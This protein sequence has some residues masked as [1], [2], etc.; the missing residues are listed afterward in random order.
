MAIDQNTSTF[1]RTRNVSNDT[2]T[3]MYVYPLDSPGIIL[4]PT[5]FDGEG[6]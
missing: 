2:S 6:Y 4:V 3:T 1:E 5:Q